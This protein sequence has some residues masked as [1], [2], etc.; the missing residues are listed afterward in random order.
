[1][2]AIFVYDQIMVHIVRTEAGPEPV[3][4]LRIEGMPEVRIEFL[5]SVEEIK[6]IIEPIIFIDSH[7][8]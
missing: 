4:S 8:L 7:A 3:D 1:M 6:Y 5:S 2:Q